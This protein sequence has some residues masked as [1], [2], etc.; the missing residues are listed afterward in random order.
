MNIAI[1]GTGGVALATASLLFQR[2]HRPI[3]ISLSG[4]GGIALASGRI[5]AKGAL[6]A[7]VHLSLGSSVEQTLQ[8]VDHVI[9]ATSADRYDEALKA[10]IPHLENRHNI[11]VSGELSMFSAILTQELKALDLAPSVTALASTLA[12]G[13]RGNSNNVHIGLIRPSVLAH[14]ATTEDQAK[15]LSVWNSILAGSLEPC[16]SAIRVL[17]SNV[18][19]IVHAPN[20]LCN[21]TRIEKGEEWSN[22]GGITTGVA[23]LLHALDTERLALGRAFGEKLVSFETQF[24][25]SHGHA[26][27]T[28][29]SEMAQAVHVQRQG[30]PKGPID[31]CTRYIT[32]DVPFGL[33]VLERLGS[34]KQVPTPITGSLTNAFSAIYNQDFRAQNP[35]LSYLERIL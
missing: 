10:M 6:E 11:L 3:L 32:E 21:F 17:L 27:G 22:Y 5:A 4:K 8:K 13:R 19:P 33:A 31:L 29:L 16:D 1:I 26:A 24:E 15:T 34:L 25:C 9:V 35:F 18:N 14:V 20:A 12:T 2:G 30:L 23:N 28:P 7:D